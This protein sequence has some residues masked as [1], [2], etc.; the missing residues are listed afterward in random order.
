MLD[1][2]VIIRS[3]EPRKS[4]YSLCQSSLFVAMRQEISLAVHTG[5]A[6]PRLAEHCGV[7]RTLASTYDDFVW[8]RRILAHAEDV[9]RF[10]YGTQVRSPEAWDVLHEY[11]E[12]WRR[13]RSRSF[14]PIWRSGNEAVEFPE[15]WFANDYHG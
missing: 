4:G 1:T 14:E 8:T 6:P 12:D 11:L 3:Q 13:C 5:I 2:G 15:M 9:T 7:P 10:V